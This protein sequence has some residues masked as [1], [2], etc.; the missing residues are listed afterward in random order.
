MAFVQFRLVFLNR[1][2]VFD[3]YSI[4]VVEKECVF[5]SDR[6]RV[7]GRKLKSYLREKLYG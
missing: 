5:E 1:K 2:K 6:K 3:S 4:I 7:D